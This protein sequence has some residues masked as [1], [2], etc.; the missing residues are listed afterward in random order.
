MGSMSLAAGNM[1]YLLSI[2]DFEVDFFFFPYVSACIRV[3][4]CVGV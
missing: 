4:S 3:M 2:V 1:A